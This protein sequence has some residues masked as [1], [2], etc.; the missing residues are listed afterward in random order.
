MSEQVKATY[1]AA[2]MTLGLQKNFKE[3][4]EYYDIYT[5]RIQYVY[6]ASKKCHEY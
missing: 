2:N 6:E 1:E 5:K 3:A 4:L